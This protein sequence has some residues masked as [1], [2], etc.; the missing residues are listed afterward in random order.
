VFSDEIANIIR[1]GP[2]RLPEHK[3]WHI[4]MSPQMQNMREMKRMETAD[5]I[6]ANQQFLREEVLEQQ[7]GSEPGPAVEI[8][9]VAN[10]VNKMNC[11]ASAMQQLAD[12]MQRAHHAHAN[13]IALQSRQEMERLSVEIRAEHEH[14]RIAREAQSSLIDTLH[15]DRLRMEAAVRPKRHKA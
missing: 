2:L 4:Y 14:N 5:E 10:A 8:G 6:K 11:S 9:F 13:G 3:V 1:D 12:G 7:R 15:A